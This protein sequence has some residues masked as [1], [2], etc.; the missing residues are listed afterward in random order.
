MERTITIDF[1]PESG[2]HYRSGYASVVVDV[3]R[4][5]T[6]AVTC[7][8][9]GRRC[10]PVPSIEAALPIAAVLDNP[11]LAGELGG[12]KPYGFE[13]T[14]S[15]DAVAQRTD[16]E[17]P[18]ILLSSSGTQLIH[19]AIGA[20]AVYLA[21]LRNVSS[22]IRHLAGRYQHVAVLGA[23]TRGEF[24]EEDQMCCALIAAGLMK[25][26][27]SPQNELTT[28]TVSRWQDRPHDAWVGSKSVQYLL[29]TLQSHDFSF[30]LSH[31]DDLD[32]VHQIVDGEVIRVVSA[33]AR[34]NA[35]NA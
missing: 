17:R 28:S 29:S 12:N 4:A 21:C 30:V 25:L 18:M 13:I 33:A 32:H 11:L 22:T 7:V 24:R 34:P 8:E 1:L 16:I 14:N 5:T 15:P 26:G 9:S 3:I 2:L 35:V 6:T 20:D 23:G 19:N 27:Y 10:F 31:I